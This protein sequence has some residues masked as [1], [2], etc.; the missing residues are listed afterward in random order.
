MKKEGKPVPS[1]D[2]LEK[3]AAA[4]QATD[5]APAV[6]F[7]NTKNAF[8]DKN[9][10]ELKKTAWLFGLMNNPRLVAVGGKLAMLAAKLRLPFFESIVKKTIFRQFCGGATLLESQKAIDRLHHQKVFSVLDY[11]VEGK[12]REDDF[13]FTMNE[14]LR[15]IEFG[16]QH[17][18]IAVVSTKITGM[19]RFALLEKVSSGGTLTPSE[20][21]EY[22]NVLKRVDT[23]SH[24]AAQKNMCL[25]IDAEET[26]IQVAI[27]KMANQMMKRYNQEK[28]VIYNTF[29]LYSTSRLSYLVESHDLAQKE[30]YLLG[31]KLVRGAYMDKERARAGEMGYPSPIQPNKAATDHDFNMALRFCVDNYEKIACCNASHNAESN[32]LMA[33]LIS[34]KNIS[35]NH[36]HLQFCQLF[37][38]SDNITFNLA[39]AGYNV[40]KYVVYGQVRDVIPYLVRRTQENT[41]ITGDLSRELIFIKKEMK[42]R[43]L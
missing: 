43:G 10:E 32:Q 33:E 39:K 35:R 14:I 37:G 12:E 21:E 28:V 34:E 1:L 13:N 19:A 20:K 3:I 22:Q 31:A 8:I 18:G 27:D 15:A 9:D 2:K 26:W 24:H 30:G 41:S 5:K 16:A 29:Q 7:S 40:G 23:I 17:P 11:G 25:Y 36:P 6:D 4:F 42:R 38:M